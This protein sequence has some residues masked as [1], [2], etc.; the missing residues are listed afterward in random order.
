MNNE[1]KEIYL[2]NS[3]WTKIHNN[4]GGVM[5]NIVF[6]NDMS[7]EEYNKLFKSSYFII[8]DKD[9]ITNLQKK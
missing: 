3:K 2:L 9:Y 4:M 1:I 8:C 7:Y 6:K 5:A